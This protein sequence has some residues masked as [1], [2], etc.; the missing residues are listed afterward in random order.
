[1]RSV[2]SSSIRYRRVSSVG[3]GSCRGK[4]RR[5]RRGRPFGS[6]TGGRGARMGE[7]LIDFGVMKP[8]NE[9]HQF[10]SSLEREF[11]VFFKGVVSEWNPCFADDGVCR[12]KWD[13]DIGAHDVSVE[14]PV[15]ASSEQRAVN[16]VPARTP[17]RLNL[18]SLLDKVFFPILILLKLI[19]RRCVVWFRL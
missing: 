17:E 5:S 11:D 14:L 2:E 1:M 19:F 10:Q 16:E 18:R 6:E 12:Y 15:D 9:D 8:E 3:L 4:M 7:A 13:E